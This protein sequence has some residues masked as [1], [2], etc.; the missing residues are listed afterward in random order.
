MLFKVER[1]VLD[2]AKQFEFC[3]NWQSVV[4]TQEN[5]LRPFGIEGFM[6]GV[7]HSFRKAQDCGLLNAV[8]VWTT[9]PQEYLSALETTG[10]GDVDFSSRC[11]VELQKPFFW[12]YPERYLEITTLEAKR[13]ALDDALGFSVGITITLWRTDYCGSGIGF[14]TP[15]LSAVQF[16]T[17]W[18]EHSKH[19]TMTSMAFDLLMRRTAMSDRFKLTKREK[20]VLAFTSSGMSSLQIAKHL[21]VSPRTIEGALTRARERLKVQNTTEAVTKALIFQLI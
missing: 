2:A 16:D 17:M 6:Y 15:N 12:A 3:K 1:E 19:L 4:Q 21:A 7:C 20:D 13:L 14:W 5:I 9:Y 10:L 18:A 11:I 8:E